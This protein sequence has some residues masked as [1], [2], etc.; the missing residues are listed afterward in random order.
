VVTRILSFL[1]EVEKEEFEEALIEAG[2][3]KPVHRARVLRQ[4]QHYPEGEGG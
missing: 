2:K 3:S 4:L 1:R